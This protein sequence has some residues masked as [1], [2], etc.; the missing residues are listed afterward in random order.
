M[1]MADPAT[2]ALAVRTAVDAATDKN[3][4]KTIGIVICSVTLAIAMPLLLILCLAVG[5]AEQNKDNIRILFNGGLL[6]NNLNPEQA[7]NMKKMREAFARLDAGMGVLK[8]EMR[9][10]EWE[11]SLDETLVKAVFYALYFGTDFSDLDSAFYRD[12]AAGFIKPSAESRSVSE[13]LEAVC[14]Y[15]SSI[16]GKAITDED[17]HN[18]TEVYLFIKYGYA[19]TPQLDGIPSEAFSD[20]AFASLMNE[21]TKYIGMRYVWGGGSPATGFDCSGFVCWS[22]SKSGVHS[23]PRTTAQGIYNQCVPIPLNDVKPGDLAFFTKTYDSDSFISHIGIM[24]GDGKMLH[25]GDPIGFADL[26]TNYWR[27]HFV[28]YGR[29]K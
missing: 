18:I 4:W 1:K 2:I 5:G 13:D 19:A 14:P 28:G 9:R 29:L 6:P 23:L 24:V 22:Y 16:T 11:Y 10:D 15:I 20:A 26:N 21:A 7:E 12:F 25:C 27:S 17:K 3:T 8:L